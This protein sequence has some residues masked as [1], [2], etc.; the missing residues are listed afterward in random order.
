MHDLRY[1]ARLLVR[2]PR[3]ALLATLTMGLGIGATTILFSVTYGVLVKPLPWPAGDHVVLLKETRG[4]SPP[5][6]G[7]FT[8]TAYSSWQGQASTIEDL[9]AWS[10][11]TATLSGAG[12]TDRIRIA[13][14]TASLFR[15]LGVRPMCG[16]LFVVKDEVDKPSVIVLADS[17][18]RQRF[19]GDPHALGRV[20]RLDNA[21]YTIVGVLPDE[22]AFPDRRTRAWIPFRVHSADGNYLSLFSAVAKLQPGVTA[23][24]AAAEGTA[25]GKFV[26]DTGMTTMAIF[27]SNGPVSISAVPLKDAMTA[28]VRQPLTV[29]L[30]AVMLL[31]VTAAANVAGLQL[32]RATARRREMAIRAALGAAHARVVRQLV[33][34]SLL[35]GF[36]GGAAGILLAWW[37]HQM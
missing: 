33:A 29:L 20:V 35:L 23:V 21:P 3:F 14:N 32:A 26:A 16:S 12:E 8:N 2:Q 7:S 1:A 6:F 19:G 4:G 28:D 27:G 15:V 25:R 36:L 17:L 13:Q 34:E 9:A 24:Q 11:A 10:Q 30:A 31:L 37:L 18:W 22:L 5:R